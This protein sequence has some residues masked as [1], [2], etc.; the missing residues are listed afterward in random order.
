MNK[1]TTPFTFLFFVVTQVPTRFPLVHWQEMSQVSP[2]LSMNH[3]SDD[4]RIAMV[5]FLGGEK[6]PWGKGDAEGLG[7]G[8]DKKQLTME[9][10][11]SQSRI[12]QRTPAA[13]ST[14]SCWR[15][16]PPWS[17]SQSEWRS[18]E[19]TT[20]QW[21]SWIERGDRGQSARHQAWQEEE[22]EE[23]VTSKTAEMVC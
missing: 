1:T 15:S 6:N 7:A 20:S 12:A 3:V 14:A 19:S 18:T 22:E 5:E 17:D 2:T 9:G 21:E 23:G 16:L 13:S 4:I 8:A 10:Y 11:Q